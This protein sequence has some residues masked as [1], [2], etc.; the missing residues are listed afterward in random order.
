[1]LAKRWV[2]TGSSLDVLKNLSC[3]LSS[4][5]AGHRSSFSIDVGMAA[6]VGTNDVPRYDTP[7]KFVSSR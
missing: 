1:L 3:L 5:L 2:T 6:K 7:S 4:D